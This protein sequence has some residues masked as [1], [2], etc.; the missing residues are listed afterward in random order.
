MKKN[1]WICATLMLLPS[2]GAFAAG[3]ADKPSRKGEGKIT[4]FS[5]TDM[6]IKRPGLAKPIIVK[7]G[8]KG[9]ALQPGDEV[10]LGDGAAEVLLPNGGLVRMKPATT[11]VIPEAV[12]DTPT[13][14]TFTGLIYNKLKDK[15]NQAGDAKDF[16]IKTPQA[17]AGIRDTRTNDRLKPAPSPTPKP[18]AKPTP[19]PSVQKP[20]ITNGPLIDKNVAR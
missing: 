13:K 2:L 20:A 19:K 5:G 18:S 9:P 11:M 7:K 12:D 1:L 17:V 4:Y 15:Y 8:T 10:I 6:K 16:T 3:P 14:P